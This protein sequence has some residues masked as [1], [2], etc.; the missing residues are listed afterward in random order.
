M[1]DK[2]PS[3]VLAR[4]KEKQEETKAPSGEELRGNSEKR[5]RARD[6]SRKHKEMKSSK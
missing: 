5:T 1:S 4:F 2:M 3:E 6:K